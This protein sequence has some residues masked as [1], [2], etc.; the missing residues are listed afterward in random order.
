MFESKEFIH[1]YRQPFDKFMYKKDM[2]T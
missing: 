1:G 2:E